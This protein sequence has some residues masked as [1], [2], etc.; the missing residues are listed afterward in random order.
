M[1]LLQKPSKMANPT[2]SSSSSRGNHPPIIL[3][4]S[5][6]LRRFQR[7]PIFIVENH[8]EVLEFVYRCFGARYLPFQGNRLVHFDSH[9][10]MTVPRNMPAE[11][12]HD[13]D[14]LLDT[15][16][17]ENW[18][19]P[20]A[21]AG[22][23]TELVW[24]K[25]P[26]AK[27]IPVG[28]TEFLIGQHCGFIRLSS[29]LEYFVSEGSYRP[30]QDLQEA[31]LIKLQTIEI[32]DTDVEIEVGDKVD[33]VTPF[34]LDI[35]L[36]FFS[37]RNPFLYIYGRANVYD[38]LKFIFYYKMESSKDPILL[39]KCVRQRV[40][41]LDE[42]EKVFNV[43]QTGGTLDDIKQPRAQTVEDVWKELI[44]LV[45]S[46]QKEYEDE[47]IDWNLIYDA[48]CT[49]DTTDL[50]HH[51]SSE[52]DIEQLLQHFEQFLGRLHGQPTV[53]TISRSSE[54]DYCPKHQVEGIQRKVLQVLGEVYG[55]KITNNPIL[56][57][58]QEAWTLKDL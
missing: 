41:Q 28:A 45:E 36:D 23:F 55:E 34:V 16:S 14:L 42:L 11:F 47:K 48:G 1:H 10:D 31:K 32:D 7:I 13:K 29:P 6:P 8:N 39:L 51:E 12:V 40:E 24:C 20:A 21:Y 57:Y 52:E 43:L 46:V 26:W 15:L 37:T 5:P 9:P 25:P 44:D 4:K 35:D 3:S 18:I 33:T 2:S 49:R 54:D 17:I 19:M 53:V 58:K 22:H 38:Q 27:Q 50:P 56:H 30:E